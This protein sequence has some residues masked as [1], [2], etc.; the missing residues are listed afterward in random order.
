MFDCRNEL[1]PWWLCLHHLTNFQASIDFRYILINYWNIFWSERA[2]V[3]R[4]LVKKEADTIGTENGKDHWKEEVHIRGRLK[5]Y[6][7][8]A[9]R[10]AGWARKHS[11]CAQDGDCFT[12]D[13]VALNVIGEVVNKLCVER[14]IDMAKGTSYDHAW[15][16]NTTW[17]SSTWCNVCEEN[18]IRHKD[19]H[20]WL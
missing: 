1:Q 18:P 17:N 10:H 11:R 3:N 2:L 13:A 14:V 20:I 12:A 19:G 15:Q 7:C 4:L 16:E 8:Q 9:I 5:H 6:Y